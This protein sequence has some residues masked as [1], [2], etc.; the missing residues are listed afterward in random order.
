MFDKTAYNQNWIP[1]QKIY[2][3]DRK[4]RQPEWQ[5]PNFIYPALLPPIRKVVHHRTYITSVIEAEEK[6]KSFRNKQF[7]MTDIRAGD[8]VDITYQ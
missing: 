2:A 3:R 4:P 5:D 7:L 1:R 8:I 6:E